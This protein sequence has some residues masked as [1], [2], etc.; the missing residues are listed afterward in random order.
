M[1]NTPGT[2]FVPVTV[3]YYITVKMTRKW[4]VLR[5]FSLFLTAPPFRGA[6]FSTFLH[7]SS[8]RTKES[9]FEVSRSRLTFTLL[10][11]CIP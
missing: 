7:N 1:K 3:Q 5:S 8:I 6:V 4:I 9:Y 10:R 11:T 2:T